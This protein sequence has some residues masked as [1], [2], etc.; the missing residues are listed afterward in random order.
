MVSHCQSI[1]SLE[2]LV[3]L[4]VLVLYVLLYLQFKI[5]IQLAG[6]D[7]SQS[8]EYARPLRK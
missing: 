4:Y 5:P 6:H 7:S 1:R 8:P 2:V 3:K